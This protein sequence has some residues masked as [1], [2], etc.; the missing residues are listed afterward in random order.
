MLAVSAGCDKEL[1]IEPP[2][3]NVGDAYVALYQDSIGVLDPVLDFGYTVIG[4]ERDI[5]FLVVYQD[6]LTLGLELELTGDTAHFR[7]EPPLSYSFSK[8]PGKNTATVKVT[9]SPEVAEEQTEAFI[10]FRTF[11]EPVD[12]GAV[13][14][15]IAVA[16]VKVKGTGL[17][18]YRDLELVFIA[19]GRFDMGAGHPGDSVPT[20][21]DNPDEV[22]APR[23]QLSDF[24]ISRCEVTN[25]QYYEFWK[26]E[27]GGGHQPEYSGLFGSWPQ[28]A[29][30]RP[31]HPVVGV[32]WYDAMAFCRWLTL[33][34]G[35]F[36]TLPTE[37]Q[38]EFACRAGTSGK[39]YTGDT[40]ADLALAGWYIGNSDNT[41]HAAAGKKENLW[42]L[43]D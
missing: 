19:G 29:I 14:D 27:K 25:Q 38:W 28:D 5:S 26:E 17:S 43:Y 23:V 3:E 4:R 41:T 39:Y 36:Y 15:S 16:A 37:A 35:E 22:Y 30:D 7:V 2:E 13:P 12:S 10:V 42:G 11:T 24:F 20:D 32:S 34:T 21:F 8:G 6:T 40:E 33:R 1:P 9:F 31:N 18:Y